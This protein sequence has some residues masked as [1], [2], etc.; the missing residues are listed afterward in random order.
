MMGAFGLSLSCIGL[1]R[2]HGSSR[3]AFDMLQLMDG[4]NLAPL[5]MGLFGI[6]EIFINIE[7][8]QAPEILGTRI[9]NLFPTVEHWMQAKGAILRGTILGFFVGILPGGTGLL[10]SFLSYGL[11]NS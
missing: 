2:I 1:D 5:A 11:E 10:S 7:K 3:L 4:I 8:T 6:S 9:K